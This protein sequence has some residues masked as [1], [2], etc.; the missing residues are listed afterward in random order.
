M[1]FFL[2]GPFESSWIGSA[3]YSQLGAP[4]L[5]VQKHQ[6]V[7]CSNTQHI[8]DSHPINSYSASKKNLTF[9]VKHDGMMGSTSKSDKMSKSIEFVEPPMN[10]TRS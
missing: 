10:A 3:N 4:S 8:L 1:L 6:D 7:W 9:N 2:G 5:Q